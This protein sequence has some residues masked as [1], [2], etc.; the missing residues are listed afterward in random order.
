MA[1]TLISEQTA[2]ASATLDFTTGI[3]STY[4]L[5][6]FHVINAHPATNAKD[7]GFQANAAGQT[8][9]N[10]QITSSHYRA[11]HNEADTA[12]AL[13]SGYP[14]QSQSNGTAY[15]T[16][17]HEVG[18]GA[19]ECASGILKIWQPSSSTYLTHFQATFTGYYAANFV[20]FSFTNGYI[21]TATAI[22]E[23]SFKFSSGNI[24][25][26]TFKLYGVT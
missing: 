3:D 11:Y 12:A 6:E 10:E 26:G 20:M 23:I 21:H 4:D 5:Y 1:Y 2:S 24:D 18:N 22:D 17:F 8:G 13:W 15:Q 16:L 9:F 25:D 14:G 19:D 7:L